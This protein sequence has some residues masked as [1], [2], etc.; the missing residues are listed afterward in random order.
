MTCT[1]KAWA[2][3]TSSNGLTVKIKEA[4][5]HTLSVSRRNE[6]NR[7]TQHLQRRRRKRVQ[8]KQTAPSF[9]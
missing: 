1:I 2:R 3:G 5:N 6:S 7:G 9:V 8:L 4:G